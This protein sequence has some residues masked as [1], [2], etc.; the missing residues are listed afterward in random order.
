[1]SEEESCE[2]CYYGRHPSEEDVLCCRYP[3]PM[4]RSKYGW[5]GEYKPK[6]RIIKRIVP[7]PS[8]NIPDNCKHFN[9]DTMTRKESC[10]MPHGFSSNREGPQCRNVYDRWVGG[11]NCDLCESELE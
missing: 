5:C 2:S 6:T 3:K 7:K 10:P 9:M 4:T 11:K 1:M 8:H